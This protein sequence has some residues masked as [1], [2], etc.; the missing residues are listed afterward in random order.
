MK[1]RKNEILY[2]IGIALLTIRTMCSGYSLL[3]RFDDFC[4]NLLLAAI[5]L[6]F[7][8]SFFI[9]KFSYKEL[10][11]Y[12]FVLAIGLISYLKI[13]N[14]AILTL[15]LVIFS[16]KNINIGNVLKI[17]FYINLSLVIT[18]ILFYCVYV[19]SGSKFIKTFSRGSINRYS[20]F[21]VH[22]NIFSMY[23]FWT[24]CLYFYLFYER[25]GYISYFVTV[26]ISYFIYL[27]PNSRT[28]ALETLI[29]LILIIFMKK[30]KRKEKNKKILNATF[31]YL[32]LFIFFN[33]DYYFIQNPIVQKLDNILSSRITLAK[34]MVDKYGITMFGSDITTNHSQVIIN[35]NYYNN[36]NTLDCMYT[37]LLLYFGIIPTIIYSILLVKTSRLLSSKENIFLILLL[38]YGI[39]ETVCLVPT[40]VFTNL[41]FTKAL[42]NLWYNNERKKV[43]FDSNA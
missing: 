6:C 26:L 16:A 24:L 21:Y 35:N 13:K 28:G 17:I 14:T 4:S 11:I 32:F 15:L 43:N 5:Y 33:I 22:P 29:L 37:S 8:V 41:F 2:Y 34:I 36:A 12:V 31:I 1:I 9:N 25:I 19:V 18:H 39:N 7:I 27:F 10:I 3:F 20:F 38:F 30:N 40:I 42:K 23:V